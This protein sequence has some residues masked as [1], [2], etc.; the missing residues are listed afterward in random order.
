[1]ERFG[2]LSKS[3]CIF[4]LSY[5]KT[6][7]FMY[8]EELKKILLICDEVNEFLEKILKEDDLSQCNKYLFSALV[9][10]D[11]VKVFIYEHYYFFDRMHFIDGLIDDL[12]LFQGDNYI[13][14]IKSISQACISQLSGVKSELVKSEL[15]HDELNK[16]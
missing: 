5:F 4:V 13:G 14:N 7:K 15:L 9:Y 2:F 10:S 8:K 3:F 12:G 1:M 11:D 6:V 16:C